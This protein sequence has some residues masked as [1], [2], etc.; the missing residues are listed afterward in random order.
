MKGE[1]MQYGRK[2][3]MIEQPRNKEGLTEKEFL[4][5]YRAGDYERPSVTADILLFTV[6]PNLKNLCVLLVKR[7]NHPYMNCWA[8]PGGFININESAFTAASRELREETGLKNIYLEQL[9]TYTQPSRDPRMRVISI[10]YMGLIPMK[11]AIA[12]DDAADAA[13]FSVTYDNNNLVF[14]NKEKHVIIEYAVKQRY[15]KNGVVTYSKLIPLLKGEEKLAFDHCQ[16]ILDGLMKLQKDAELSDIVF[17]LVG[18]TFTLP[19]LQKVYEIILGHNFSKEEFIEKIADTVF[20]T[21]VKGK[22]ICNGKTAELYTYIKSYK[23]YT[24]IQEKIINEK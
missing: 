20:K 19:D 4:A 17:N 5:Q 11:A 3:I 9:H 18:E 16:I 21:G 6:N 2:D 22:S 23:T 10:A 7:R 12:G 15:I 14:I 1:Q 8:L 13:W 24:V